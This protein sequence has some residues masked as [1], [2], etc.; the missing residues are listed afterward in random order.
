L[1]EGIKIPDDIAVIGYDDSM[2][3]RYAAVPL[4]TV[5]QP[6]D[7]IGKIVVEVIQKRIDN[8][9]VGNRTILKP[10]LIIRESCGAKIYNMQ[11]LDNE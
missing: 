11:L 6:V 8:M 5:H 2:M 4:T 9:G 1:D 3:S 7:N 10:S